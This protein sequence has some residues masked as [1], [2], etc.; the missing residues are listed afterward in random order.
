MQTWCVLCLL[1]QNEEERVTVD[2]Y[3]VY[4]G[5]SVCEKC[6]I[7]QDNKERGV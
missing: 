4:R 6:L 1:N 3:F 7:K 5:N 2:A